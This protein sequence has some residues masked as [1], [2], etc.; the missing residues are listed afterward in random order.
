MDIIR[1]LIRDNE[2]VNP[3]VR[4]AL[5][6]LQ[7]SF[8]PFDKVTSR[9][10]VYGTVRLNMHGTLFKIYTSAD[11]HIANEIFYNQGYEA[12]EFRLVKELTKRSHYFID[13][14]ANT[15][16]FSI[17]AA[18]TNQDLKILSFEP[19]P[20]N[21]DRF[22]KNI[23]IN[24][25][26]NIET[27]QVAL[28]QK[29]ES[30]PFTIPADLGLSTTSS[31]NENFTTHFHK[32]LYKKIDVKQIALDAALRHYCIESSDLIKVDVEYYELD[33]LKG[34]LNTL[35]KKRP[36]L[37]IEILQYDRLTEQFPEMKGK[38]NKNHAAEIQDFLFDLGYSVYALEQEGVRPILSV[39]SD[40]ANRNFLFVPDKRTHNFLSYDNVST[41]IFESA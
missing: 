16:I 25:L 10:R 19:H 12:Y 7:R 3:I 32:I 41:N 26:N 34:A 4:N 35:S 13:I 36:L 31:A 18:V 38:I 21:M 30:I 28:G 39:L 22:K 11:D 27:F 40:Y 15:G 29:Q 37:L 8:T 9:Y 14:G 23:S 5:R 20:S 33:V 2:I 24:Q 6:F 17:Y 1:K